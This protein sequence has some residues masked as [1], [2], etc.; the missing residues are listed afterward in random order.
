M[1]FSQDVVWQVWSKA[2]IIT[3]SDAPVWRKDECG[4]WI[5]RTQYGNRNSPYG[6]EIDHII[7]KSEGGTDDISN[8]RPLEWENNIRRQDG[9]L[10]CP[11]TAEGTENVRR[12][13]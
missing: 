10:E 2:Y 12:K 13:N 5:Q 1:S 4:A 9:T 8:L 6:W 3:V 7:P 11:V